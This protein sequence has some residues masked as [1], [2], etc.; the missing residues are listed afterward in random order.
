MVLHYGQSQDDS[1]LLYQKPGSG[2]NQ[3]HIAHS[4]IALLSSE[5]GSGIS[6]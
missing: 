5:D 4:K 1:G 6:S 3:K 2:A